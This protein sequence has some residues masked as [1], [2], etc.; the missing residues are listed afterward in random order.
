MNTYITALGVSI[1]LS[2]VLVMLM[3]KLNR[4]KR[5]QL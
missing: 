1:L 2:I 3:Y 5:G 4:C